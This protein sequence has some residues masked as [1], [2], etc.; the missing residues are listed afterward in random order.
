M[1]G[2]S[3][4]SGAS[5]RTGGGR[6]GSVRTSN[7]TNAAIA[8]AIMTPGIA[9]PESFSAHPRSPTTASPIPAIFTSGIAVTTAARR[10]GARSTS[11][12]ARMSAIGSMKP[13]T[14]PRS[15]PRLSPS[16]RCT[17]TTKSPMPRSSIRSTSRPRCV[18]RPGAR[19]MSSA[20]AAPRTTMSPSTHQPTVRHRTRQPRS[21]TA[22]TPNA[23]TIDRMPPTSEPQKGAPSTMMTKP[24]SAIPPR[25]PGGHRC[26]ARGAEPRSR[27]TPRRSRT[28]GC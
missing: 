4:R 25:H 1:R 16:F 3:A 26:G 12:N 14:D 17:T 23:G 27:S 22:V 2:S 28:P 11:H 8:I 24:R 19:D 13:Q 15:D 9:I 20:V 21:R 5:V 18:R 6:S 7:H 10:F